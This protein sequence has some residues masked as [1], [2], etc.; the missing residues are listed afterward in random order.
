MNEFILN[1]IL[2]LLS[3]R[4]TATFGTQRSNSFYCKSHKLLNGFSFNSQLKFVLVLMAQDVLLESYFRHPE[5][6]GVPRL[7]Q[8]PLQS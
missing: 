1:I 3:R 4:S 5:P 6:F 2:S 8:S 7:V